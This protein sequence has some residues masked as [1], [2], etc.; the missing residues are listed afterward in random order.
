MIELVRSDELEP[1][2]R[3][4]ESQIVLGGRAQRDLYRAR[5]EHPTAREP[6]AEQLVVDAR[7]DRDGGSGRHVDGALVGPVV[8]PQ[9]PGR[10]TDSD[11]VRQSHGAHPVERAPRRRI[12]EARRQ[13]RQRRVAPGTAP[14]HGPLIDRGRRR[15]TRPALRTSNARRCGRGLGTPER[16]VLPVG[17]LEHI[18][19]RGV[20]A[21]GHLRGHRR[22]V[23][24]RRVRRR[25]R[26]ENPSQL[27]ELRDPEPVALTIGHPFGG[28]GRPRPEQLVQHGELHRSVN[29]PVRVAEAEAGV[30]RTD[31]GLVRLG[32]VRVV[33]PQALLVGE[34]VGE[35]LLHERREL[36]LANANVGQAH[37][38]RDRVMVLGGGL[39]P[40]RCIARQALLDDRA[41]IGRQVP[42][43]IQVRLDVHV[44]DL[45]HHVEVVLL[46]EQPRHGQHLEEDDRRRE[47][48]RSMVDPT[49]GDLLGAHVAH[50]AL[51]R[52]DLGLVALNLRL[53]DAEIADLHPPVI[54]QQDVR[55]RDVTVDD[56]HRVAGVVPRHVGVPEPLEQLHHREEH[57][58]A[59]DAP[60]PPGTAR[61]HVEQILAPDELHRDEQV[62]VELSELEHLHDVRVREHRRDPRLVDEHRDELGVVEQRRQDL[63]DRALFGEPTRT[64]HPSTKHLGHSAT[65][66]ALQQEVT[67]KAA[68][69]DGVVV[70][71]GQ[72]DRRALDRVRKR[73]APG[74]ERTPSRSGS[75]AARQHRSLG[76]SRGRHR[77]TRGRFRHAGASGPSAPT[78]G[79]RQNGWSNPIENTG[80]PAEAP[81]RGNPT[82]SNRT[83]VSIHG[84]TTRP[85]TP[86]AFT[87]VTGSPSSQTAPPS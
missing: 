64:E 4:T 13:P 9:D 47:Q 46:F 25:R 29:P 51:L 43:P 1:R 20:V 28:V 56:A 36:C 60:R 69:L 73:R 76:R 57:E 82:S 53:G 77:H 5:F 52:A 3:I 49:A 8:D 85:P 2:E 55:R 83:R 44:T 26:S 71:V 74:S 67:A 63:L 80:R 87:Q 45:Q 34:A 78:T 75:K 37:E 40:L 17:T 6:R 32:G 68:R 70:V 24:G 41:Q 66:D 86:R 58:L 62:P 7:V 31:D 35:H 59:R 33:R 14:T 39:K 50:L 48:V 19:G 16:Q 42:K 54:R 61:E 22:R 15:L 65:P 27:G 12:P 23:G 72:R 79:P 18:A 38:V 84:T 11:L 21:K 81:S 10:T 30:V